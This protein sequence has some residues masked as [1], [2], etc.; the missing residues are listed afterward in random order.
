MTACVLDTDVVIAALDRRD[1]HH[2]E[3]AAA[4]TEM[5]GA[6]TTL[7]L[8]LV[9]YAETLVKP[10]ETEPTMRAALNALNA[11]GIR[12]VAPT[13]AIA[14]DAAR[15]RAKNISL[16]DGFAIATAHARGASLASFDL[17]VRRALPAAGVQLAPEL[18]AGS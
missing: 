15:H 11:L 12:L 3:A 13:P 18:I 2:P 8:S 1:A 16:A 10:A 14:R 9:N 4:I 6:E 7:L 17:R 5:I